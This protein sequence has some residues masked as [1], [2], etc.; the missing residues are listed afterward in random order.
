M[1]TNVKFYILLTVIFGAWLYCLHP[2][3][4][5][6][7]F[8][9][10]FIS[11]LGTIITLLVIVAV[12]DIIWRARNGVDLL[13]TPE[14]DREKVKEHMLFIMQYGHPDGIKGALSEFNDIF[15]NYPQWEL[16]KWE[17]FQA[18]YK[19]LI[20]RAIE[21]PEIYNLKMKDGSDYNK[22]QDPLYDP[23]A[24]NW[25]QFDRPCYYEDEEDDEDDD[26]DDDYT[27]TDNKYRKSAEE[28]FYTGLGLGATDNFLN[29]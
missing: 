20:D 14:A 10:V 26:D 23:D 16:E 6:M 17:V 11:I 4:G 7:D 1:K 15:R 19:Q 3:F 18:W 22:E 2:Y 28:G 8:G 5:E 25:E 21:K 27:A 29:K 12:M 24:P 13:A 9:L